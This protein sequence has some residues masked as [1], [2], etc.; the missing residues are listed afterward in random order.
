MTVRDNKQYKKY[1]VKCFWLGY[2]CLRHL[3]F[4]LKQ[5]TLNTVVRPRLLFGNVYS[6]V[7]T[8]LFERH[9]Q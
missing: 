4:N 1:Q 9:L 7:F 5:K 3:Y 2:L 6:R 8:V